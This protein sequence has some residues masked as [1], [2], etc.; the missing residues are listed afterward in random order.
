KNDPAVGRIMQFNIASQ[1][2]SVDNP[3]L[4]LTIANSCGAN[5]QSRVPSLDT[6]LPG[7]VAAQAV[8]GGTLTEQIPIVAPVRTR[9]VVWGR[10]GKG[11]SVQPGTGTCIPDCATENG[12]PW[13]VLVD[14]NLGGV[15][16][17]MNA[18]RVSLEYQKPG[19][20]EHWTY[21]NSGGGWDHPIHLHFE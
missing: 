7:V 13:T 21:V 9:T 1:V 3:G 11:D 15:P 18:N 5:D 20:I 17:S 8:R 4:M 14:P 19:D 12:F 2:P 16:H 10:V 6:T